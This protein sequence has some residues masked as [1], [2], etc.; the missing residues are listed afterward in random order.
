MH[1][2]TNDLSKL[3]DEELHSKRSDLQNK[4]SFAYRMGHSDMVNQLQL[5]LGDY[6]MEVETRN[7]KMLEQAQKSGR[8]GSADD[9]AKDI[10]KD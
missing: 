8:L 2:L 1:P 5:V 10:T 6:A 7:H 3:T 9:T 4:L